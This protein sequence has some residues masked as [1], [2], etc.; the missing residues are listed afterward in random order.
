MRFDF[1]S[2]H[3][4]GSM[5][6]SLASVRRYAGLELGYVEGV[7]AHMAVDA[8]TRELFVA[9]P[10]HGR[11]VVA[12]MDSGSFREDAKPLFPIFSSPEASFAYEVWEGLQW[13]VLGAM[14]R[15]SGL[16]LT[17]PEASR[18]APSTTLRTLVF[19]SFPFHASSCAVSILDGR[20]A[21][22]TGRSE[23][24]WIRSPS[25]RRA[26]LR[27]RRSPWRT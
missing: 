20:C 14:P 12:A 8:A 9:D 15:P 11:L 18:T 4:P 10:G 24:S 23:R 5:D 17:S 6:H 26:T 25:S 21:P 13:A 22:A 27:S 7:P 19:S 2:D 3:G 1:E 16:A